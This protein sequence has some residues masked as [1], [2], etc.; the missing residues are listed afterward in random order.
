MDTQ[1]G[2][3]A[4][5]KTRINKAKA[6]FHILR[7]VEVQGNWQNKKCCLFNTNVKSVLLL[8]SRNMANEQDGQDRTV[9]DPNQCL[10]IFLGIK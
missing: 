5:V 9:K 3:E 2:T 8:W 10:Q 7:N 6:A 1:G 4:D